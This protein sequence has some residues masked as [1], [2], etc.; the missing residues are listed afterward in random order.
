MR[1]LK[2]VFSCESGASQT[3]EVHCVPQIESTGTGSSG[4]AGGWALISVFLTWLVAVS[5]GFG[6]ALLLPLWLVLSR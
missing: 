3:L 1:T 2:E 5:M 6:T 4:T